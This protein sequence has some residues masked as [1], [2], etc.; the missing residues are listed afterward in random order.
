MEVGLEQAESEGFIATFSGIEGIDR[1]LE[2]T[3]LD[4]VDGRQCLVL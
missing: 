4:V 3:G 2:T 1:R